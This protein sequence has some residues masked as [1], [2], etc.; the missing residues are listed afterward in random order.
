MMLRRIRNFLSGD[1]Q[2]RD[3]IE[4]LGQM[5]IDLNKENSDLRREVEDVTQ[6]RDN[7]LRAL[8]C[9]T[10]S[11][12]NAE[13]A[14]EREKAG[15]AEA[16]AKA[17][18]G[19]KTLQNQAA[20]WESKARSLGRDSPGAARIGA[21]RRAQLREYGDDY[22]DDN[23]DGQELAWAAVCYA[24]PGPVRKVADSESGGWLGAQEP[25]PWAMSCDKRGQRSRIWL[26]TAAGALIAA[27]IDRLLRAEEGQTGAAGGK[28]AE[29][30]GR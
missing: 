29:E 18:E 20:F 6:Q 16:M 1:S 3:T 4:G 22:D 9:A 12:Q 2:R 30:G 13:I 24:A 19:L 28:W 21:E 27:E 23:N 7:A 11:L 10:T 8:A 5:V 15:H 26:L 14:M 17:N 25:W